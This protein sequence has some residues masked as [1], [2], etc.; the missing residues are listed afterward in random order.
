MAVANRRAIEDI[1]A[2]ERGGLKQVHG[3]AGTQ[4]SLSVPF[5]ARKGIAE[6]ERVLAA[7]LVLQR[8]AQ[9]LP[10]MAVGPAHTLVDHSHGHGMDLPKSPAKGRNIWFVAREIRH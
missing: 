9:Q 10:Q 2:D 4:D 7:P 8:I 3:C 1:V 6:D 5:A